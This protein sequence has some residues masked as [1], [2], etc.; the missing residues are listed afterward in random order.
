M[1]FG[2]ASMIL[3]GIIALTLMTKQN[4]NKWIKKSSTLTE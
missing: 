4:Y 1:H 2:G 3:A